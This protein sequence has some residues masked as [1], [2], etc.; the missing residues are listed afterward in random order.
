[1]GLSVTAVLLVK[2]STAAVVELVLKAAVVASL[3]AVAVTAPPQARVLTVWS[4]LNTEV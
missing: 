2:A 3:V 4:S 1:V